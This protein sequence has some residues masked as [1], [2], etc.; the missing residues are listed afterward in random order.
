MISGGDNTIGAT[1]V[2]EADD[3]S[4][5][6]AFDS[7]LLEG[8]SNRPQ[9]AYFTDHQSKLDPCITAYIDE[10]ISLEEMEKCLLTKHEEYQQ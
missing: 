5:Q 9:L 7:A 4:R 2:A 6:L 1:P 8:N 10:K 3:T